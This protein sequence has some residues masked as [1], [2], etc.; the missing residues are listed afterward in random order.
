MSQDDSPVERGSNPEHGT[1][2]WAVHTDIRTGRV[3]LTRLAKSVDGERLV[4]YLKPQPNWIRVEEGGEPTPTFSFDI[5]DVDQ[6]LDSL[7][8]GLEVAGYRARE[9]DMETAALQNLQNAILTISCIDLDHE[10]ATYRYRV[11][12]IE[13]ARG[14]W[15]CDV[16]DP[17]RSGLVMQ[18]RSSM[19]AGEARLTVQ[20]SSGRLTGQPYQIEILDQIESALREIADPIVTPTLRTHLLGVLRA[21]V[22]TPEGKERGRDEAEGAE[23]QEG[24]DCGFASVYH[25]VSEAKDSPALPQDLAAA[26]EALYDSNHYDAHPQHKHGWRMAIAQLKREID[27]AVAEWEAT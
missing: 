6:E 10:G 24:W 26:L 4:M 19:D 8:K 1:I 20:L 23:Q 7:A 22:N 21:M 25:A 9:Y 16:H 2:R 18:L 3:H 15:I 17:R 14:C 11:G 27:G 12:L 5:A 13:D